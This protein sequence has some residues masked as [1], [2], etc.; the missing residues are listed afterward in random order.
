MPTAVTH[1]NA[2]LDGSR[3]WFAGGFVG[4][5]PGLTTDA[6]WQYDA[7]ANSWQEGIPLPETRAGGGLQIIDG[8]LHYFGGFAADRDTTCGEHWSLLLEGGNG[9]GGKSTSLVSPLLNQCS[10]RIERLFWVT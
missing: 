6:V 1:V 2:A 7:I 9:V 8:E 4:N 3:V 5:H 10:P